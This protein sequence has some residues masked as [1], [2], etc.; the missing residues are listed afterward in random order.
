MAASREVYMYL[1]DPAKLREWRQY[2]GLSLADLSRAVGV[3]KQFLSQLEK[4]EKRTSKPRTAN[5][6]EKFLLPPAGKRAPTDGPIFVARYSKTA[7]EVS[8]SVGGS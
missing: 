6:I 4:G 8:E 1:V 7:G 5:L 3:S 2:R